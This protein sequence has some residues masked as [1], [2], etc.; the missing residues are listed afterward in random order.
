MSRW[1]ASLID[2]IFDEAI[3]ALA[4]AQQGRNDGINGQVSRLP[5]AC[6]QPAIVGKSGWRRQT[7]SLDELVDGACLTETG[8]QLENLPQPP[9]PT[10]A[11]SIAPPETA[12]ETGQALPVALT[13]RQLSKLIALVRAIP[14]PRQQ[15]P[16]DLR[17][18]AQA[19]LV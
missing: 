9:D 1:G 11:T 19:I 14:A 8:L 18:L 7:A 6:G 3:E 15:V 17:D 10:I 4:R 13:G 5:T 2:P 16:D 12:T